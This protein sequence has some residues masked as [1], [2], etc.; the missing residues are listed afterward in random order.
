MQQET[1]SLFLV[2][3]EACYP[4]EL[5]E[6]S[7]QI[8]DVTRLLEGRARQREFRGRLFDPFLSAEEV[9]E[10][11]FRV[12]RFGLEMQ[13][14][15]GVFSAMQGTFCFGCPAVCEVEPRDMQMHLRN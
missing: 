14:S 1:T 3:T 12:A 8:L 5:V 6:G 15:V 11:E 13:L 4:G 2:P 10:R 9:A 7:G